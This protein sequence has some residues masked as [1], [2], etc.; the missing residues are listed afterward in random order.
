MQAVDR[1]STDGILTVYLKEDYGNE[2]AP[3]DDFTQSEGNDPHAALIQGPARVY[4]YDLLSYSIEGVS[5]GGWSIDNKKA[6]ITQ[7]T[8][9]TA[10]VE[11]VTGKSGNFTLAYTREGFEDISLFIEIDSL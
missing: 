4:P 7:Q 10:I 5:G 1:W 11:V 9:A 2:W 6:R 3:E 8:D